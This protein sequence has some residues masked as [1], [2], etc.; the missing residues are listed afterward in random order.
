LT[1]RHLPGSRLYFPREEHEQ[2]LSKLERE[3][4]RLGYEHAII[5]QRTGGSYDR[6][7][8]LYYLT[9]YASQAAGQELS[10][11]A[12]S[13]G[14]SFAALLVRPG[15]EPEL[16]IAE[17]EYTV[18][19]R[20][21][22]I[23]RI[24]AHD[25]DLAAGLAQRL[26]Q[27]GVE[28]RVAYL[29]DD[30]LPIQL[31]RTLTAATPAIEWV[32]EEYL[33]AEIQSHKSER[34]LELY[35]ECGEIA[36]Q[37]LTELMEGLIAGERQCD[38]A[39]KAAAIVIGAGGGIQRIGVNTGSPGE[40]A[41]WDNPLYG[42][43]DAR[44]RPGEMVR[45]WI[46]GPIS[47][48]YWIDPGRTAIAANRPTTAQRKLIEDTVALTERIMGAIRPGVT[49]REAGIVG[50]AC[51]RELGYGFEMGGA[52]WD[53]YGHSLST[54]WLGPYIPSHG[55]QDFED[56]HG[57]WNVDRPFHAGQVYT[58]ETFLQEDGIGT[59][60]FEQVFIIWDER[61]ELLTTT[62]MIF[63]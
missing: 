42:Y 25:E 8:W 15:E 60:A 30:F 57:L 46:F 37:A 58:V 7:G 48:G 41:M 36:S 62:P 52:I 54:L 32:P 22:A 34:E 3:L 4:L 61:L 49:P 27:L 12:S 56:D 6:A 50:D 13:I 9:N 11:G 33:L 47:H 63:W 29:G 1:D 39:A 51:S 26:N 20:Y 23:D 45:G 40:L 59:A 44:A 35:R 19:R 38:A 21:V 14:K 16:H 43:S 17:P 5:W 55:A 24:H 18:D 28:G 53:V 31:Y 10:A 2:R